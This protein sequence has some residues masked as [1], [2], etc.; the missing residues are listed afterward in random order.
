MN[1][2]ELKQHKYTLYLLSACYLGLTILLGS[3]LGAPGIILAQIGNM[4]IRIGH[5]A[6]FIGRLYNQSLLAVLQ[7]A[8][9]TTQTWC[10]LVLALLIQLLSGVV[11]F[12]GTKLAYLYQ[13][14]FHAIIGGV[15]GLMVLATVFR[16]ERELIDRLIM[17]MP[18]F[19]RLLKRD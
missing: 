12:N 2:S 6:R 15:T 11:L 19:K 8:S 7:K 16:F 3:S 5:G 1:E 13:I 14:V 18:V 10:A 9:P 4:T 17:P